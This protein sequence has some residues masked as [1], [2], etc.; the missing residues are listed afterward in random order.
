MESFFP[1]LVDTNGRLKL[2]VSDIT[3]AAKAA[4]ADIIRK[5]SAEPFLV[6]N[7]TQYYE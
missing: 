1:K 2:S 6:V 5:K 7:G 4:H 3:N